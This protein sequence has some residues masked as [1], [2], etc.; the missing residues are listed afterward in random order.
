MTLSRKALLVHLFTATGAVFAML[1]M[2]AAVD[3]K[4][5]LMFLWLVVAFIVDGIDGPLARKF[6]VKLYI[7][8]WAPAQGTLFPA[9]GERSGKTE[10]KKP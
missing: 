6:D 2:L 1:A 4:W 8:T 7:R 10:G 3:E 9:A 5:S